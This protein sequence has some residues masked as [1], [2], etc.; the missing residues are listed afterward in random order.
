M[1]S[2]FKNV[3]VLF[4]LLLTQ[5]LP[6]MAESISATPQIKDINSKFIL[7]GKESLDPRTIEKIDIMGN[8]LFVKT[9]IS[10]YIYASEHYSEKSFSNTESKI[11]FIK[12]F[13]SNIVSNLKS[14]YIILTV[15]LKDKHVNMLS[16][17]ELKNVVDRDSILSGYII[18]LLAS[19]DKNSIESKLSA[20][21]L[22]GYSAVVE[23]VAKNRGVE[24][25]SIINGS[26]RTF[27]IIWKV[28]MYLIVIGGLLAYFYA[29][30]KEKRK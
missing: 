19:Y 13:E 1:K 10:V 7:N 22:N 28:F 3:G 9:G 23:T 11:E 18:P 4:A 30:W 26:G 17:N 14:P 24:V 8:E 20:G 6:L 15:S 5:V 21:L 25:T 2:F 27:A 12:S 16:S 29:L